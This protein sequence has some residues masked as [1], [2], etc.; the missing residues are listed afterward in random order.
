[1]F[2]MVLLGTAPKDAPGMYRLMNHVDLDRGIWYPEGGIAALPRAIETLAKKHGAT[3]SYESPVNVIKTDNGNATGVILE[4]GQEVEADIVIS[5]ADLAFTETTLLKNDVDRTYD[6][7]YWDKKVMAPSAL[8]LYLGLNRTYDSLQHHNLLF[9]KDWDRN[10]SEIFTGDSFPS[11]PS[12]YVCAPSKTDA[13][14]APPDCENLFVLVPMAS[15]VSYDMEA[16]QIWRDRTIEQLEKHMQLPNLNDA[17]VYEKRYCADD[18]ASDY[19]SYKGSALGLA[20]T[21]SQSALWRPNNVSKK[22]RNLYYVGANTNPGIGMP[23]C[24]ISAQTAY[25]RI[26]NIDSPAP[27]QEL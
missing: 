5:D 26:C 8:I 18:F 14:V 6:S 3:F 15:D 27:L 22:V 7:A 1:M 19:N 2:Q 17:I 21:L 11:D 9:T 20:H 24:I 13:S 10:F 25:K 4:D 12:I 23:T 16:L